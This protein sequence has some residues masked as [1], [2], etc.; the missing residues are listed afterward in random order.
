MKAKIKWG[1]WFAGDSG[2]W[3]R[4]AI[5]DCGDFLPRT[6]ICFRCAS[7]ESRAAMM[8]RANKELALAAQLRAAAKKPSRKVGAKRKPPKKEQRRGQ[9]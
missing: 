7:G 3:R 8:V 5:F 6:V 1:K 2:E 4:N 9:A